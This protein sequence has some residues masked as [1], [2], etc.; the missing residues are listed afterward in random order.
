MA[1]P[2]LAEVEAQW[3]AQ[4]KL[5]N[6]S[7]KF[8]RTNGTNWVGLEDTLVQALES[9]YAVEILQAAGRSRSFLAGLISDGNAAAHTFPM[10]QTYCRH[11]ANTP[12]LSNTQVM[13]DRI[14]QYMVDNAKRATSRQFTF[15]NPAA[16]GGNAGNGTI[17][18]LTKDKYNFDIENQFADAKAAYCR[19]DQNTGAFK[20]EEEFE[21]YDQSPGKDA[22]N[23]SGGGLSARI[24]ALSARN[25]LLLNPSLDTFGN[26]AAAPTEITSWTSSTTVNSTNYA[27]D[28][29]NYYRDFK[30]AT[31]AALQMNVTENISQKLSLKGTQLDP[32][33]PYLMRVAW[34]RTVGAA[35]G[36]LLIRQGA[37]SNS[38][39]A[40]AQAG[41]QLLYA[42]A[43]P[44]QNYWHRQF[45]EQD[46]DIVIDWTRTGGTLLVD[47]IVFA[48]G[49]Q[50]DGAWY[51]VIGG[52]TPFLWND[53][54]TWSDTEVGALVQNWLHR[55]FRRYFPHSTGGGVTWTNS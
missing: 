44:G 2:S 15:N 25:S 50:F 18:R 10:L 41:W 35:S 9:D 6:E 23:Y 36:T 21:F 37:V 3:V 16:G 29:T 22:L 33:V 43:S 53:S 26:T 1:S 39:V 47:D 55:A 30:G 8:A 20:H 46:M 17:I 27:F 5:L 34:N 24:K 54:F 40:A 38:V 4:V 42:V 31:P 19:K 49:V 11:L 45:N 48:P 12:E 28:T 7:D 51:W 32:E 52:S 13:L 14:F